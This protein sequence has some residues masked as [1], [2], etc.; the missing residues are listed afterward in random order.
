MGPRPHS[1]GRSRASNA[2]PRGSTGS[3]QRSPHATRVAQSIED[4]DWVEIARLYGELLLISPSPIVELNRAI[5]VGMAMAPEHGFAALERVDAIS[6]GRLPMFCRRRGQ[7]CNAASGISRG[8]G[9]RTRRRFEVGDERGGQ[10]LPRTTAPEV[11]GGAVSDGAAGGETTAP[12]MTIAAATRWVAMSVAFV[13]T[14]AE[15]MRS[16]TT[17]SAV[18]TTVTLTN[19]DWGFGCPAAAAQRRARRRWR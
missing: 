1:G 15:S 2:L 11:S 8:G 10:A 18:S 6:A 14:S 13:A 9:S 3:K 17:D 16:G 4:T 7:T 5:A 19:V 12:G